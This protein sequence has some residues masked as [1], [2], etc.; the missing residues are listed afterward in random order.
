MH[1]YNGSLF[2]NMIPQLRGPGH[3]SQDLVIFFCLGVGE[4]LIY[5]HLRALAIKSELILM[6][7]E[8]G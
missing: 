5:F 1:Y 2:F 4:S 6:R 8:I 3:K 7:D